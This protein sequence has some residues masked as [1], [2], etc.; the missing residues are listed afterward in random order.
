MLLQY[1]LIV[2]RFVIE[3]GDIHLLGHVVL[4]GFRPFVESRSGW[5]G[6]VLFVKEAYEP[7]G[8]L[9]SVWQFLFGNFIANAPQNYAGMIA[10]APY[11]IPHIPLR[12][13]VKIFAVAIL[14]LRDSPHIEGFIHDHDPETVAVLQ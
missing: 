4:N 2:H 3:P 13:F 1:L 6:R 11:H 7:L 8:I 5:P 12:P 9:P 14:D 10:I